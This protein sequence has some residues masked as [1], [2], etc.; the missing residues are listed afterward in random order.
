LRDMVRAKKQGMARKQCRAYRA[1]LPRALVTLAR[2]RL[3]TAAVR[4]GIGRTLQ[5][6]RNIGRSFSRLRHVDL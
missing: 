1:E 2:A 5:K 3:R 6:G 4:I